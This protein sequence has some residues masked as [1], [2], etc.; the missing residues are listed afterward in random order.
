MSKQNEK[1][2]ARFHP[3]GMR[4]FDY[5]ISQL[6][7]LNPFIVNGLRSPG[8]CPIQSLPPHLSSGNLRKF[9]E[10][11]D[12]GRIPVGRKVEDA[13]TESMGI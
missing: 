1:E 13:A 3:I 9:G 6:A 11:R 4:K 12:F 8:A 2:M 7:F 10:L 5:R